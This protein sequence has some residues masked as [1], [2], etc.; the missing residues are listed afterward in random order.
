MRSK[1]ILCLRTAWVVAALM[2]LSVGLNICSSLDTF[3]TAS[4]GLLSLM[5]LLTFPFGTVCLLVSMIL[6]EIAG[7]H[8][9]ASFFV[10]WLL[11]ACGGT[12]QWFIVVPELIADQSPITLDLAPNLPLHTV[13]QPVPAH[14]TSPGTQPPLS[15]ETMATVK[16]LCRMGVKVR[17]RKRKRVKAFDDLG[18]T[19]LE[20]VIQR[21]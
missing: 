1:I 20:R 16:S 12:F 18:R 17:S 8:Y 7:E 3:C 15:A 2:I 9:Q 11:L 19:P 4:D 13:L 6:V 10:Y 14:L 5:L 21:S